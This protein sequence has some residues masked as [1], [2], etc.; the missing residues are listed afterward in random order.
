[1]F[2]KYRIEKLSL[3][4]DVQ[5]AYVDKIE[6]AAKEYC[7]SYY[8]DKLHREHLKYLNLNSRLHWLERGL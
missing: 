2:L 1:M 3:K 6:I 8:T 4:V 5:K 7:N